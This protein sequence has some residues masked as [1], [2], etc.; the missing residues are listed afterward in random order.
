MASKRTAA[1]TAASKKSGVN[2]T[3]NSSD[4]HPATTSNGST[5]TTTSHIGFLSPTEEALQTSIAII[6]T[7]EEN[8]S[9]NVSFFFFF[10][11]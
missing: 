2:S 8:L 4:V 6:S 1:S 7:I 3:H 9:K 10:Q 5:G 11:K